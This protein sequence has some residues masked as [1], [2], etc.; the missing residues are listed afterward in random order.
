M[1]L[2]GRAGASG[3]ITIEMHSCRPAAILSRL[4]YFVDKQLREAIFVLY[5]SNETVKCI[6][7]D[8]YKCFYYQQ[9][10]TNKIPKIKIVHY[11]YRDEK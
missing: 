10:Y 11:A 7:D 9:A 3:K 4:L 2:R 6:T 1:S 8:P 5:I